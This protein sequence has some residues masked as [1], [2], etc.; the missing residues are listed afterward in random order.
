MRTA[1][2]ARRVG[3]TP[4]LRLLQ[5]AAIP[6]ILRSYEHNPGTELSFGLEAAAA[7][8]LDPARIYKTLLT[9]VDSALVVAIL[10]V[11]K[12]LDLK[13]LAAAVGGRRASFVEP[14]L[15]ERVTGYVTGGISPFAQRKRLPTVLDERASD[16]ET[17]LVSAGRR[18]LEVEVASAHL[19][20]LTGATTARIQL[21]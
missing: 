12:W 19:V 1:K 17:V 20:A 9:D 6:H 21:G 14:D 3:A 18:G 8:G 7:L 15:A 11:S 4:A 10:A 5:Q 2:S 16:H 13:A